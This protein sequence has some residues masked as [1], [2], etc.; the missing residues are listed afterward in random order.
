MLRTEHNQ[1]E[2]S[3]GFQAAHVRYCGKCETDRMYYWHI[4]TPMFQLICGDCLT[5]EK[6][7]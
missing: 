1:T 2:D 3:N 5:V 6:N 7:V 4:T